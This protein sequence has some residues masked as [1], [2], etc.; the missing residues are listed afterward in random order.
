ML[1][2]QDNGF[3][4]R[5]ELNGFWRFAVDPQD[6]GEA[7]HWYKGLRK[8]VPIAVPGS[9]NEQFQ[10]EEFEGVNIKD[11]LGTAWF[12]TTLR[13]PSGWS[14]KRI[15]LRFGAVSYR[16][17][18]WLNG[19]CLGT[20]E[21]GYFPFQVAVT[22]VVDA[23]GENRLSVRVDHKLG[24]YT[25]PAMPNIHGFGNSYPPTSFDY[26]PYSG[27]HRP[28]VLYSTPKQYVRDV[29]V[30][31]SIRGADGRVAYTVE[32]AGRAE[33]VS[34]AVV[35]GRKT[36][37]E[38]T[39]TVEDGVASGHVRVANARFWSPED[40][41]L[42]TLSVKV[43]RKTEVVDEYDLRIG[44]RTLQV[45]GTQLL[46]NGRP[47]F[48]RGVGKHED[49]PV[50]GKSLN[51][52]LIV[53]D[54]SLMK[55]MGAN[56]Y[57]SI[58]YPYSEEMVQMADEKGVLIM[59]EVP[60]GG[61]EWDALNPKM[62]KIHKQFVRET[63]ERDKNHP[64]I[65]AWVVANEPM[66]NTHKNPLYA[67]APARVKNYFKEVIRTAKELDDRPVTIAMCSRRDEQLL[68]YCDI[69]ALNRYYGWYHEPGNLA[70]GRESFAAEL[71]RYSK[72]LKMPFI[73][74]ECGAG[75]IAGEHRDPPEMWT[76][77][78]QWEV[79]KMHLGVIAE[80]PY[81][82][83]LLIWSF[84]DFKVASSFMRTIFNRKGIFTRDRQPKFAAHKVREIWKGKSVWEK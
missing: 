41:H 28:V 47:I 24:P 11:Y 31:T 39:S 29:T 13:V 76:E 57:R 44:I 69:A 4:E 61:L 45:K 19:K 25:M 46:L 5:K 68:Q 40:P 81:V 12:E 49:F 16:A 26:F 53:K 3:R 51:R 35:D 2:P 82:C 50:L 23:R 33:R 52:S 48:M 66:G 78:Y 71:D 83:G 36:V 10:A 15:W 18:V 20:H 1:Y 32:V 7:K 74:T 62:L 22:L 21:G 8:S 65:I 6:V 27:I 72:L 54:Y 60:T 64:S 67:K 38:T 30:K 9:W 84:A 70:A 77:E 55:W 59:A 14:G 73:I 43:L 79:I 75:A 37:A 56:S 63:L 42:Y 17:K 58:H 34:V 80:R